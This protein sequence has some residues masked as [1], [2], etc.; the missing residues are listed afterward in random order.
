MT[1]NCFQNLLTF[2]SFQ[3][4]LAT[5]I[6]IWQ[7]E[8]WRTWY[9]SSGQKFDQNF[10][11]SKNILKVYFKPSRKDKDFVFL[12]VPILPVWVKI[13][14][15]NV[16]VHFWHFLSSKRSLGKVV[17]VTVNFSRSMMVK[18]RRTVGPNGQ[19]P[20]KLDF[21]SFSKQVSA[22]SHGVRSLHSLHI[23]SLSNCCRHNY[24]RSSS[25][26]FWIEVFG[27]FL[28]FGPTVRRRSGDQQIELE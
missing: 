17:I 12:P 25:G 19:K 3:K 18:R 22:D 26:I 5:S 10:L 9:L 13:G 15:L 28:T 24:D 7:A 16:S 21:T 23:Q 20:A 2:S 6:Q 8:K 4:L 11:D 1:I 27:G 14:Y